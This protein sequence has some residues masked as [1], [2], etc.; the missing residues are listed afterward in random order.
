MDSVYDNRTSSQ[1]DWSSISLTPTLV[2]FLCL[3]VVF[4]IGLIIGLCIVYSNRRRRELK[5]MQKINSYESSL[6]STSSVIGDDF[7]ESIKDFSLTKP[8]A[9]YLP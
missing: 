5:R 4:L 7:V 1:L 6:S 9:S 2:V 3:L 8:E